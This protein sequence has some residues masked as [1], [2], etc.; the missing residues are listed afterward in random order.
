ME[1]LTEKYPD[2]VR[3]VY[4]HYPLIGTPGN[5]FHESGTRHPGC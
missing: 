2:E 5:P 4:R 3:F 1:Q